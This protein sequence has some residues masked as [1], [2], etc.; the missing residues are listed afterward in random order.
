M[1]FMNDFKISINYLNHICHEGHFPL[2]RIGATIS[3]F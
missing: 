3:I 2:N 1:T